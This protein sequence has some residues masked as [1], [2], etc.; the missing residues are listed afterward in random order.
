[1]SFFV[2]LPVSAETIRKDGIK[3]TFDRLNTAGVNA[4]IFNAQNGDGAHY[5][6]HEDE[7]ALTRLKPFSNNRE[8][9]DEDLLGKVCMEA[10]MRGM[11]TYSHTMLYE[12]G[13]P[14]F[15]PAGNG[16]DTIASQLKCF[17]D[18]AQI[19][20]LGEEIFELASTIQTI[21]NIIS[22]L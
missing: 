1:M 13:L 7:Y 16:K 11:R 9:Y 2:G 14:D 20:C 4:I 15:W 19:D 10:K 12:I 3:K 17:S 22:V 5:H 8:D 21:G 18:C 6:F